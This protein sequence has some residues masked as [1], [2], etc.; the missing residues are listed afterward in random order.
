MMTIISDPSYSD[1]LSPETIIRWLATECPNVFRVQRKDYL[2]TASEQMASPACVSLDLG[3]EYSGSI[4]NVISVYNATNGAMYQGTVT[5]IASP[6]TTIETDIPWEAGFN[7]SYLNDNTAKEGFY[8]EGKLTVNGVVQ[9]LT[10]IASPDSFGIADLDVSGILRIMVSTTKV[11]T[12][13]QLI[14]PETTKSGRFTLA[15]RECWYGSD[16]AYTEEGNTWYYA[17]CIRSIEQGS[18]LHEFVATD[19]Y[20]APFLNSFESPVFFAGLPFDI[21][22]ILP[23][24]AGASPAE[25]MTV[26]IRRYSAANILLNTSVY[27][28]DTTASEGRVNSLNIDPDS[29]EEAAAYLTAEI[30]VL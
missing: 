9:T 27:E 2:V 30:Q 20:E 14:T 6:A 10:V 11:G 26:T 19:N 25:M 3:A 29:I 23:V 28:I 4:G 18:N 1:G 17:E 8:Y 16:E 21:S 22:F 13:T 15:I 12:Y 5:G 7:A 24:I